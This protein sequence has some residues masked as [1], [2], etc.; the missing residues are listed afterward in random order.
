MQ[1]ENGEVKW[2][3]RSSNQGGGWPVERL[4]QRLE[5]RM[6]EQKRQSQAP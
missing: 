3:F 2:R 4:D 6:S 5:A 1:R